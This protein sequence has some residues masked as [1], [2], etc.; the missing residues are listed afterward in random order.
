[1]NTE[2]GG[3]ISLDWPADLELEEEH[4]LDTTLLLVPG[5]AKG[6]SE[7]NIRFF[8]VDALKRGFFPV[9]MNPRG[10]A[11]SP[12][13][14]ASKARPWTT[15]MGVGW[16]YG[17]N[18]LTKYLAEVG[19]CTPLTA[20]TCI[21]NPFDL[22]EA[23]RCSPY[24]VALDQKLTGG[25][26]DIL[27]SN[28]EIFQGRAKGFDVENALVSKSVRDFE[29]AISMVSY[30]FEE[31]EDFYSKSST[32]GMVGN[33]KI[34]V[35]FIQSDD[36]TVPPFSIPRS[37]IAENPFT[38]LLLC[39]CVPSS[40]VESGR[41]A[42]SWCQNLT[43]EWLI[44]VELGLLKGRHPLLKDVDIN[45][46]P[47]KGLTRVESR[48]KQVELNNLLS[49]SPTDS[50]GYTIEPI[51]KMLQ[52]IQSRSRKDSQRDL[53]LDEELQGVENDAVQQ[54]RSVDAELIEQ[55]SADS[56]DI[57]RG[58]VLPT[59]QVV[60][61]M[62]DEMMPDTL[63]KEKK[64]QVLTAV[65][66]GETLIKALQ[67]AVPEEVVGKLTTS[68]SGILQ[69]QH[70]NL[71]INGLLSIG[72]VPNVPKTKIQE[73][74]REV[75]SAEV[76]SKDPHSPDHMERA[77]DLTDGS[78]NNHPG[79]EK[80]GAAPEQ[81][82]HSSKNIQKSIETSQSQVMSSQQGDPSGSD[83]KEPNESGHKNE[84]DDFIKEKA[85]SHSDS[86]EKGLET[87]SN[88][89]ITS[90][91][92]KAGSTEEAIV[93]ESKV[94]QG[95][96]SADQNRIVSA[97]M[98]EEPLP[99]AVSATDSEAI[100]KVGN[101]DQKRENKTMQPAHDQNKPP[102]SDSNPPTFS[103]TQALDALTGMDDSTQVAVN[104]VFGVLESM[105][106]Q[107]EEE[108]DHENKI[109]NKNEVEGE[110][111]D[112]KPKKLE[113]AN[114][115]GKQSDTLQHPPVHKLHESGGNQQNVASSGLVEEELTEDPILFSGNGTRG[116]QG[117][118]A[119]NY[120][121]KEEQKKDQLVSG[122]H[123]AGYDGHVNSIPLYVTANPSGDFVQ[124]KYFHRYLLSKIPNSKPLDLDTTTALLLDYFPEEGKWKL[125][126]QPG[127]T[128]DSIGGVTTSN[129]PGIKVQVHSSGKENDGESYIE[130]S[131]VVLDTEKQQE[132]V[133]EYSTVENFTENDDGILDELM[134]F[135][136]IVV[137][138]ALRIEVDR[139]LGA[140]SKKEMKSYFARDLEL[141]AD[142]VS[143]AIGRNK[144][145]TWCL[146][147][148]YHRIEG[149]E[150]KVGT[151]HGEHIV[152]A[153][154]SSVLRTN[155][156]R[157]L[158]PVGVII[159][160]SLAAL[161][162]YFNV[163]TRNENDIKSSG[164]T[165]NH[166]Q[167]SQ[168]KV[169]I[170]EMD[171]ELT[172]KTGHGT[173]FNSSINREGEEAKL[174]TINNDRVMVGAVTAALGASALL[175]QQQDPSNSKEGGESS[176][177]LL[178]ERGNLLEPAE[179]LEVAESEKNPNIVTSLA[180]KAM[181]V[182]GPVVPT[183]EDG[184]VDQERLV[185]ML[186]DLGQKGGMLKLVG[187][188]ALLWGGIRGAMSLTDKL[189]LFL[190]IAERPLYQ[191]IL[192]FAGMVLVLWS[193]VIV[194]LLPT[195]VLSWTTSNPSR[196]AEF[197]CI[198]GLYAAIMILV[199]LWGRRIR[200]Y[201]DPLEQ[202]GLDLTALPKIQKYL[203]GLIGGVLLVVSIQSLNALLGCVSF[204]WPS[205]IPSSSLDAMTWLKMYVQMIMLAGRGIIT[206]TGIVLVEELLFR[207]WL[208]EEIA[209][210][211][212][213]HQAIIISGLAFSLFQRSVWAMPGLWLF[214]LALAGFRQRSKGSLSI[215]IGLRT[216]IMASSF[217]LQT[218]G[219]LT[220]KPNY[221][222]WV[223]G[224][225]P[226]QPFSGAIG[227]AFSLLMAI[228][229]YPWQPLEE[230]SLGRATQG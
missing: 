169:C 101:G 193:P 131:Y 56:V 229:L 51:N 78:V 220:Y 66:Q 216:G 152:K 96:S 125:L 102:T 86:S 194:P 218:G 77:E 154:S 62:L 60:M 83:R 81:E 182:A 68:V 219:L 67:D 61:N 100:E 6:S 18:M 210:D 127:I 3:V 45:I 38:S 150:E 167:R 129:D 165:Q 27:Q 97:N 5:T 88:P 40:A 34:P 24:D 192:G 203:W 212:G 201:E 178:K 172:I 17:A 63:T 55:D 209:A 115:S 120:E 57:E 33:V 30:G 93:D 217:V 197:V 188:I 166:G 132:P 227:L 37:L 73:K 134:E 75:S 198:V 222:V 119:S 151:V 208:P 89:N 124:N 59:A 41:A 53:K 223:T 180:E 215:P 79:T 121:I 94:E 15:L 111:V 52:D 195:L 141:V 190:H 173:S 1:V 50:S 22:E 130:P 147:G 43:I 2:D 164:Q 58:Q 31:I 196:F 199:T 149:A 65:G 144:D 92:E 204:S 128:G 133:E 95:D 174:K 46:N 185:A 16:G 163:A 48:D 159:G 137:L 177:K 213:Y 42:V 161:R 11:A 105:I 156:L 19:E 64:K 205:S 118:I 39:S 226:L 109:K 110:L 76:T 155:Y 200:G 140:A 117:D 157:R 123:L 112:S 187:K 12:I 7:D 84:S 21:N 176:S 91:S 80:S 32:R 103:V 98:T 186:A 158:L 36:G 171:H 145:H 44:A 135:V 136:K 142:A 183:K 221:P 28:K 71:N 9:V 146:K 139:K 170:K 114:H 74:V 70:S 148:K 138:D 13:T 153:I 26:I 126:E 35:L 87:S 225:H 108:T 82:L 160:S 113:N 116:S 104:S 69:A 189:I 23:T 29:K 25:L 191:R 107:L 4:G 122:K 202:Y 179:K 47:S 224:T 214:S 211:V 206:A 168:D 228:F 90:R 207:S 14:T 162:K 99:P 230:K 72:E 20:A 8:V 143:L 106:S 10:C 181:S 184:G 175:V 54:R 49:L 85:A